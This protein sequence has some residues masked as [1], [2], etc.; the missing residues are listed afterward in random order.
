LTH[1]VFGDHRDYC[2]QL[3][4]EIERDLN[5]KVTPVYCVTSVAASETPVDYGHDFDCLTFQPIGIKYQVWLDFKKPMYLSPDRCGSA[6]YVQNE[7]LLK[8][9]KFPGDE[10]RLP[11]TLSPETA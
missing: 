4:Q 3:H 5:V 8:K 10:P 1:Y 11:A 6:F 7:S 9:F 2:Q